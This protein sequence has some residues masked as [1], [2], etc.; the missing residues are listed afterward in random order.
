M[1]VMVWLAAAGGCIEQV[2][3]DTPSATDPN[4]SDAPSPDP[5]GPVGPSPEGRWEPVEL[6]LQF[7]AESIEQ[8][9]D[10]LEGWLEVE[11]D[12]A[13]LDVSFRWGTI[14]EDVSLWDGMRLDVEGT[15][16]NS[17]EDWRLSASGPFLVAGSPSRGS[18]AVDL[19]CDLDVDVPS[20]DGAGGRVDTL[21]CEGTMSA[22]T[23][24]PPTA[25]LSIELW[26]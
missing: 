7:L 10:R 26:D 17:D 21:R 3:Q 2:P 9:T 13:W 20:S 15:F 23:G 11:N 19:L 16:E 12:R 8:Q 14:D 24:E 25:D 22:A 5:S 1:N 4:D 6:D 18:A